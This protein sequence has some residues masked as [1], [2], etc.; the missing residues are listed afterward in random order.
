MGWSA[1][2]LPPPRRA[3]NEDHALFL[4]LPRD[5]QLQPELPPLRRIPRCC[6]RG[7]GPSSSPVGLGRYSSP[8]R[9]RAPPAV[10]GRPRGAGCCGGGQQ[11]RHCRI[12]RPSPSTHP[13]SSRPRLRPRTSI[14]QQQSSIWWRSSSNAAAELNRQWRSSNL[15]PAEV[16]LVAEELKW[17][18]WRE[19]IT[20]PNTCAGED[21]LSSRCAA[22]LVSPVRRWAS[23]TVEGECECIRSVGD[24]ARRKMCKTLCMQ[25]KLR[26]A[27]PKCNTL[28]DST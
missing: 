23:S 8:P 18:G 28:L 11:A 26:F 12:R 1:P 17:W 25:G 19:L 22:L 2:P 3:R 24:V 13:A 16:N 20:V 9:G 6:S 15:V 27:S 7:A 4:F 14:H 5:V 21:G 10:Q